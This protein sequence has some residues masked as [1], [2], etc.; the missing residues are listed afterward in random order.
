MNRRKLLLGSGTFVASMAAGCLQ[1][2]GTSENKATVATDAVEQYFQALQEND[3]ER[4]NQHAHPDGEYY[5]DDESDPVLSAEGLTIDETEV[6]DVETGVGHMHEDADEVSIDERVEEERTALEAL[7]DEYGF[8]DYAY[9]R[10]DA[11]AEGLTFNSIYV[12]FESDDGWVIW[13]VPTVLH[14]H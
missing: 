13:S 14:E 8:D 12:L 11:E 10:H 9:V 2:G 5:L 6:V 3:Q 4:A 1:A 7:Q